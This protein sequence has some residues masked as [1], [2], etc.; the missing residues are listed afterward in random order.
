MAATTETVRDEDG[1]DW[2]GSWPTGDEMTTIHVH[3][4]AV[5]SAHSP[6]NASAAGE[7]GA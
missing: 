4:L 5:M 7:D 6:L 3:S 1:A 2:T